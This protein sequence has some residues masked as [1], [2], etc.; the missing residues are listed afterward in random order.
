MLVRVERTLLGQFELQLRQPYRR[1][2]RRIRGRRTRGRKT[3]SGLELGDLI[4]ERDGFRLQLLNLASQKLNGVRSTRRAVAQILVENASDQFV[5]DSSSG[6]GIGILK[7]D[8]EHDRRIVV[9]GPDLRKRERLV[10]RL[11]LCTLLHQ[12]DKLGRR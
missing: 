10:E 11:D 9:T 8:R 5:G 1:W 6:G 4:I 7:R 12:F 2:I 3:L